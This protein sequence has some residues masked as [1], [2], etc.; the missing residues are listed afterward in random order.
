MD[1]S[2]EMYLYCHNIFT[3][4][5]PELFLEN[6]KVLRIKQ[7]ILLQKRKKE[8]EWDGKNQDEKFK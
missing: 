4:Y 5:I 3:T 1:F 6:D 7:V 8:V 2:F